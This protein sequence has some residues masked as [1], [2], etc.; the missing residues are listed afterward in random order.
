MNRGYPALM[1]SNP[2]RRLPGFMINVQYRNVEAD[3]LMMELSSIHTLPRYLSF[4]TTTCSTLF[5]IICNNEAFHILNPG[6]VYAFNDHIGD[7][8]TTL[9]HVYTE[10]KLYHHARLVDID[11]DPTHFY[12]YKPK[13]IAS[14]K[15]LVDRM[16]PYHN[17]YNQE[18]DLLR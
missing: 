2:T 18:G 8:L 4:T 14:E 13:A 1:T 6:V 15:E 11:Y 12:A 5:E 3:Q 10:A 16:L 17:I 7:I 9:G